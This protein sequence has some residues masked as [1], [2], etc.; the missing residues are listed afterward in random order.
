MCNN[1]RFSKRC[2]TFGLFFFQSSSGGVK[3]YKRWQWHYFSIPEHLTNW[4]APF[5]PS[6]V[7]FGTLHSSV[8]KSTQMYTNYTDSSIS[9]THVENAPHFN[10]NS[11]DPTRP[12]GQHRVGRSLCVLTK[13]YISSVCAI[14]VRMRITFRIVFF[15]HRNP[16]V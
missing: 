14:H 7:G 3:M 4:Y 15:G 6:D 13:N 1:S 5:H 11:E 8:H 9:N 16:F 10:C 12:Y 2:K